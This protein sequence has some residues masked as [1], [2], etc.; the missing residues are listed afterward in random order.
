MNIKNRKIGLT[1][2]LLL[3]NLILKCNSRILYYKLHSAIAALT[4]PFTKTALNVK[5]QSKIFQHASHNN[6]N[7]QKD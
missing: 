7:I 4:C 1:K 3:Y 5:F 2:Q 6:K